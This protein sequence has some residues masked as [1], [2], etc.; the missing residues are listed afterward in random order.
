[1][2]WKNSLHFSVGYFL[3]S[4]ACQNNS[5]WWSS[6]KFNPHFKFLP[7][8]FLKMSPKTYSLRVSRSLKPFLF[9]WKEI[10]F[11]LLY[12]QVKIIKSFSV[13]TLLLMEWRSLTKNSFWFSTLNNWLALA[14]WLKD[15]LT[16]WVLVLFKSP[17]W[18][19]ISQPW[20]ATHFYIH[21]GAVM[22]QLRSKPMTY[23]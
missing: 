13:F 17:S 3:F 12:Y 7:L 14:E 10:Y 8:S 2:A 11:W 19:K 1:M 18:L 6:E 15:S 23:E 22:A 4:V 5:V 21:K 9:F 16:N 20:A